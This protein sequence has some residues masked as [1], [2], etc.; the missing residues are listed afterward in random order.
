ML[1][2]YIICS[3]TPCSMM[4]LSNYGN[5]EEEDNDYGGCYLLRARAEHIM[6]IICYKYKRYLILMIGKLRLREVK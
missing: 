5:D 2:K 6:S 1:L 3:T 4:H